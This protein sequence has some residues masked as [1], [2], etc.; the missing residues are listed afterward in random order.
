MKNLLKSVLASLMLF[1]LLVGGAT[2]ETYQRPAIAM[3]AK[4]DGATASGAAATLSGEWWRQFGNAELDDLMKQAL[5]ANHE[6]AAAVSRIRQ[7]RAAAG[8]ADATLLPTLDAA[9]GQNRVRA[10][11][12][13]N[14]TGGTTRTGTL[15]A[16]YEIDL[17]G[18]NASE[19]EAARARVDYSVYDRE[20]VALVLQADVASNYFQ[21]LALK[22]RL[23]LARQN[24]AAAQEMQTLVEARF[25]KGADTALEVSQQRSAVLTVEA[26]IPTLE[27]ELRS[28]QTALAVLLGKSPQGFAIKGESLAGLK[29]PALAGYLPPALLERRPDIM[30]AEASLIAGNADL[31]VARAALY[32]SLNLTASSVATGVFSSGSSIVT[33]L[34]ASLAQSIFDGGKLRSQAE[35]YDAVKA[36]LIAQYMQSVLTGLKEVQDS[37]GLVASSA[38]RQV[39]MSKSAQEAQET[40]RIAAAKYRAGSVHMLT[41]LDSQRTKLQADDTRV[42]ADLARLSAIVSLFKT[43]GGGWE[44]LPSLASR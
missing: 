20:A 24:M 13:S 10:S 15:T 33:T 39:I 41:L 3:P 38:S 40:Y 4:W 21:A 1:A 34:A 2:G 23:A 44:G 27:Q 32:P 8:V 7:A 12:G 25:S 36:E 28:T 22:E 29:A 18:K 6:L 42:Q 14:A 30:K 31:V 5:A 16:A 43:L 17:W 19:R 35:K 26:T 9:L 37:Y 11:N